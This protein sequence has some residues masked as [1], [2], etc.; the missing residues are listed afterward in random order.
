MK[1]DRTEFDKGIASIQT[2]VQKFAAAL[3]EMDP[4]E[5]EK[6]VEAGN[7][8]Y[9]NLNEKLVPLRQSLKKNVELCVDEHDYEGVLVL[10]D[11]LKEL[12]KVQDSVMGLRK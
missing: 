2:C 12:D 8:F 1:I 7:W 3:E 9:A 5:Q 11:C 10:L 4:K 6:I